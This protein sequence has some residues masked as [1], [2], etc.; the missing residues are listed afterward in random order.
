[1]NTT[2]AILMA[3]S[4]SLIACILFAH[5]GLVNGLTWTILVYYVP[6][7]INWATRSAWSHIGHSRLFARCPG[8]ASPLIYW[9]PCRDRTYDQLIKRLR[10]QRVFLI[11][12]TMCY[13]Y[14]IVP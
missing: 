13:V 9:W 7:I 5:V 10:Y 6:A 11:I 14:T 3:Q 4:L 2:I 1:M 12:K 8:V